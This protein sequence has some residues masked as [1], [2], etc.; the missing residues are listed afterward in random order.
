MN[1]FDE[2]KEIL[3]A[4]SVAAMTNEEILQ[5]YRVVKEKVGLVDVY[6]LNELIKRNLM[7]LV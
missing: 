7:H 3:D 6:Y 1:C 5:N 2:H 4:N